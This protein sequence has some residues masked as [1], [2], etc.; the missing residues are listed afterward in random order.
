M[1]NDQRKSLLE[2]FP[3]GRDAMPGRRA[4]RMRQRN[5]IEL[6]SGTLDAKTA[7]NDLIQPG[8]RDKLRDGQFSDRD[9]KPRVQDFELAIQPR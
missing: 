1:P 7:T 2:Q 5:E 4:R 8:E 6:F 3:P 9:D